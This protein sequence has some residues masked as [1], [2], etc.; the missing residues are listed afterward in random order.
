[1][2]F[3]S[4]IYRVATTATTLVDAIRTN[5][6]S[7]NHRPAGTGNDIR[8]MLPPARRLIST[9]ADCARLWSKHPRICKVHS[10][11]PGA[12]GNANIGNRRGQMANA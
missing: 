9:W 12:K 4:L 7:T 10:S 3:W 8:R 2:R 6:L 5:A 11:I 1:L